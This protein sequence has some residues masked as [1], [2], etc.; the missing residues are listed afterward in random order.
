MPD[1]T[2]RLRKAVYRT[3]E[4]F[5]AARFALRRRLGWLRPVRIY[6]YL[7]YGNGR[8]VWLAGRVLE[9]RGIR[10]ASG[11]DSALDNL[12]RAYRRFQS[13]EVPFVRVRARFGG[14]QQ[15][16]SADGEGYFRVHLRPHQPSPSDR[17]WHDVE[18]E[19]VDEVVPG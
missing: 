6:P 2:R 9:D 12:R 13:D 19:L 5:D 11:T 16:V 18:V 7:G 1:R 8:D 17:L 15:V 14:D 3:E 10:P 4:R